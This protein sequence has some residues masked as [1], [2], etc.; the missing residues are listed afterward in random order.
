M[1]AAAG[2]RSRLPDD[3]CLTSSAG[4]PL[5]SDTGR[6]GGKMLMSGMLLLLVWLLCNL[7]LGGFGLPPADEL[8]TETGRL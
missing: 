5:S 4:W 1:A 3:G 6:E 7:G 2:E 8:Y